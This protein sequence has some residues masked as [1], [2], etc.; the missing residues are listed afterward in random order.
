[1]AT[2]ISIDALGPELK[3][4]LE[5]LPSGEPITVLGKD[6]KPVARLTP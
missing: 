1:M 6:G 3:G 4:L 5:R 2:E